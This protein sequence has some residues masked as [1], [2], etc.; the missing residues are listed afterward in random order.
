MRGSI[1][2]LWPNRP[3]DYY[4][5][6]KPPTTD[7]IQTLLNGLPDFIPHWDQWINWSGILVPATVIANEDWQHPVQPMNFVATAL[8]HYIAKA[9][10]VTLVS[11]I[12]GPVAVI[13]G[14]A[15]FMQR[16]LSE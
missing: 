10:G 11:T 5:F 3:G 6:S 1:D 15:E 9:K 4:S 8:W 13:T 14:D 16:V 7:E 2:V 12:T